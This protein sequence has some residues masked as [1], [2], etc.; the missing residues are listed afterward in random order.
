[1][2]EGRVKDKMAVTSAMMDGLETLALKDGIRN[3]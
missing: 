2:I 3:V 1:M